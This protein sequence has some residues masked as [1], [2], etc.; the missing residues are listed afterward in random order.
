MS[1]GKFVWYDLLTTNLDA[2]RAFYGALFDWDIKPHGP[3]YTMIH[4]GGVGCGGIVGL[5]P[6]HGVPSHWTPYV[7]VDDLAGTLDKVRANGGQVHMQHHAPGVGEFAVIADR[8]GAALSVIQLEQDT[9]PPAPQKGRNDLSWSELHTTDTADALA[10]Y[11]SLFDWKHES[12][13]GDYVLLGDEHKAG[14]TAGQPGVPPHWLVYV[15]VADAD[16]TAAKVATLGGR[17]LHGPDDIPG[18]GRFAVL[19]DPTGAVF[20]VMQNAPRE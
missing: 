8:Q 19:Q 3:D 18:V 13:G 10:F 6:S 7:S 4:V 15:N 17:L 11:V 2:A 20:A 14:M 16:A 1:T 9:P 12:W 5:D